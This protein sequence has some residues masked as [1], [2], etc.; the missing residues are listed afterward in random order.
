MSA[1]SARRPRPRSRRKR[2]RRRSSGPSTRSSPASSEFRNSHVRASTSRSVTCSALPSIAVMPVLFSS[3]IRRGQASIRS[4]DR[5]RIRKKP[6]G[7]H[8]VTGAT[9]SIVGVRRPLVTV[10]R[11]TVVERRLVAA[12][13][14]SEPL[15]RFRRRAAAIPARHA[16]ARIVR[17][18]CCAAAMLCENTSP[19]SA[20]D[21]T[22]ELPSH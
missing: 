21:S 19:Y 14:E 11:Y 15:G 9:A 17:Q 2:S 10:R 5:R 4:P 20:A 7:A 13:T 8:C 6:P 12:T 3:T 16:R 22:I 1:L 18:Y